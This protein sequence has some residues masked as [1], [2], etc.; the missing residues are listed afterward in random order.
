MFGP[1]MIVRL[2]L[3]DAYCRKG[4]GIRGGEVNKVRGHRGQLTYHIVGHRL[5]V[6]HFIKHRMTTSLDTQSVWGELG[7][8]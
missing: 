4:V 8:N 5:V 2:Q 6:Y 7:A 3:G 1:V